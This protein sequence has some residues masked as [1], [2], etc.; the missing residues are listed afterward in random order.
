ERY[1]IQPRC[2]HR[3]E[4]LET[5]YTTDYQSSPNRTGERDGRDDAIGDYRVRIPGTSWRLDGASTGSNIRRRLVQT[6]GP[7]VRDPGNWQLL[8]L[9]SGVERRFNNTYGGQANIKLLFSTPVPSY[10]KSGIKFT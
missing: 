2:I 9:A 5:D 7:D 4:E 10:I 1:S 3:F 8:G 6:G